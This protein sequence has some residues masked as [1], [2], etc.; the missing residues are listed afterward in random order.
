MAFNRVRVNY[1]SKIIR[2][3]DYPDVSPEVGV[4]PFN[5]VQMGED[6]LIMRV[7][8]SIPESLSIILAL[9]IST[10]SGRGKSST[11]E[12]ALFR[13]LIALPLYTFNLGT[14]TPNV[15][16]WEYPENFHTTGYFTKR[17]YRLVISGYSLYIF[18]ILAGLT[19]VWCGLVLWYCWRQRGLPPNLSTFPEVDFGTKCVNGF[20]CC[21]SRLGN[22]GTRD[23]KSRISGKNIFVGAAKDNDDI[24]PQII[25]SSD[26][27]V[28]ALV[29]RREYR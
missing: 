29:A 1:P 10:N 5:S 18:S 8:D 21:F 19:L 25:F 15:T 28:D 13:N 16:N 2:S 23:I 22:A 4:G 17:I 7:S 14:I 11:L 9:E 20:D 3:Y 24:V 26:G 6:S 12:N 27:H